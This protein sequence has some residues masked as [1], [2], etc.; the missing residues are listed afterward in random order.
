MNLLQ[1]GF[2]LK[3]SSIPDLEPEVLKF[4]GRAA[5]NELYEITI[6]A[7]FAEEALRDV[8]EE[9]FFA[10]DVTLTI[11]D[12]QRMTSGGPG[13]WKRSW[14]GMTTNLVT[15]TRI[16]G[17]V[18]AEVTVGPNLARLKGQIHNRIHLDSSVPEYLRESLVFGGLLPDGMNFKL[19][20]GAYPKKDFVFQRDE[21]LLDFVLRTLEHE[22]IGFYFDHDGESEVVTFA[23]SREGYP[24][25]ADGENPLRISNVNVSGLRAGD[26]EPAAY[27]FAH[28]KKAPRAWIRLKDY[29][30]EN[31]GRPLNVRI[32]VVAEGGRGE[33][34]LYGENFRTV[35]EG[36]AL[37]NIR[38]EEELA[39]RESFTMECAIPGLAPGYSVNLHSHPRESYDGDYL[40]TEVEFSGNQTE[41]LNGKLG[42]DIKTGEGDR[43]FGQTV[44]L[45]R[46]ETVFRP[47]RVTPKPKISGSLTGWIDGAGSGETPEIDDLG[48]YK[49]L[50]PLD[51][52]GRDGGKASAWIR[53]AQPYVGRGYGQNFPLTPGVEVLLT[54]VDGNPD[55]PV[56]SG[57]LPNGETGNFINSGANQVSGIGTRG[58]G[59]VLFG[60]NGG[61]Q[62]LT[63]SG[64]SDRGNLTIN[65][66]SPTTLSVASDIVTT[67]T[68]IATNNS[69]L[70]CENAAGHEY[71]ISTADNEFQQF[72]TLTRQLIEI[73]NTVYEDLE[74]G[75]ASPLVS[76][77]LALA[78]LSAG[79]LY[80]VV[81]YAKALRKES[82]AD[83]SKLPH[84]NLFSLTG[85]E[86]G[87]SAVW[88]SKKG[89][90]S[91]WLQ[92]VTAA[93][94]LLKVGRGAAEISDRARE[95]TGD[96][97]APSGKENVSELSGAEKPV[98]A[99]ISVG[100]PAISAAEDLICF[101]LTMK[102][103][104]NEKMRKTKGILLHNKDSYVDVMAETFSALSAKGPAIVESAKSRFA[105]SLRYSVY[106]NLASESIFRKE[107]DAGPPA[108]SFE[109][110]EAVL[111]RSS[112]LVRQMAEEISL[113]ARETILGKAAD[114]IQLTVGRNAAESA[115]AALSDIGAVSLSN[116][117]VSI[118]HDKTFRAGIMLDT[119]APSQPV[120]IRTKEDNSEILVAQG[121]SSAA[122]EATT[123]RLSLANTGVI[124][125]AT[126][127]TFLKMNARSPEVNLNSS[128]TVLLAMNDSTV[129]LQQSPTA[130]LTL[131]GG[132]ANLTNAS[133]TTVAGGDAKIDLKP[134]MITVSAGAGRVSVAGTL[135]QIG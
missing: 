93:L 50:F 61:E 69:V 7:L 114:K 14:R 88:A 26:G 130:K 128:P 12:R 62:T 67:Q 35:A 36:R 74:E 33:L 10:S 30:W 123:R 64:G 3:F 32:P 68:T 81:K 98:T 17:Y 42:V 59:A 38:K 37:A 97:S 23:D 120:K 125:G 132:G 18:L 53:M 27:S 104:A 11:E 51:V 46:G 40:I 107:E 48:R 99:A 92:V 13:P 21:D 4:K 90:E 111:L 102:T 8:R 55:R 70:F 131:A 58:G 29:D 9:D 39:H 106:E 127:N 65:A 91:K 28:H 124:L 76:K 87:A 16:G 94:M 78:D 133:R 43:D 121:A 44:R 45:V 115:G 129:T 63:L 122:A 79:A 89:S 110:E 134:A 135:I 1:A 34:Y 41:A 77:S 52:S 119:T 100:T 112:K 86:D 109:K 103:L 20:R 118:D 22:G 47:K 2:E 56:I 96:K 6:T 73:A 31:P 84:R 49:V 108:E 113:W 5:L 105:E 66:G 95:L 80:K 60:E 116:D 117:R 75:T 126:Q 72:I 25:L 19:N 85:T 71:S 15:G 83:Y 57:A 54:F 101:Y 82:L 24:V